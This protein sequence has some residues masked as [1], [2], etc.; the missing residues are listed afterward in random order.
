MGFLGVLTIRDAYNRLTKKT[1]EVSATSYESA[2]TSLTGY[3]EALDNIIGGQII[4]I[5]ISNK[6]SVPST[7]KSTPLAGSNVDEGVTYFVVTQN[8]KR[9]TI[10]TP[11]PLTV[12]LNQYGYVDLTNDD[13]ESFLGKYTSGLTTVSDGEIVEQVIKGVID[14][15]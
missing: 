5:S 11:T 9:A 13:V 14:K 1:V 8:G 4:S 2:V 15:D 6:L 7:L 10:K 12:Y 3:A